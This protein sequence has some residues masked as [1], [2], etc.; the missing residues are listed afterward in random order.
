MNTCLQVKSE[1]GIY[2]V[3]LTEQKTGKEIIKKVGLS[4]N[5]LHNFFKAYEKVIE[6]VQEKK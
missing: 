6:Q 5:E 4:K 3:L 2:E 1:N